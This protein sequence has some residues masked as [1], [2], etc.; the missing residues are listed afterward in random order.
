LGDD[1]LELLV[2]S[3]ELLLDELFEHIQYYLIEKHT[4]WVYEN[5]VLI[6]HTIAKLDNCKLKDY[7]LNFICDD[8]LPFM[9][10]KTFHSTNKEI[11]FELLKR[12]DLLIEEITIWECLIKWGIEQTPGLESNR[13]EWNDENYETLKETL[14]QLIP[15]IRFVEISRADFYDK[16]NPYKAIIPSHI[17]EEVENFYYQDILP[18]LPI[19]TGKIKSNI[20]KPELADIISNWIDKKDAKFTRTSNDPFYKFRLIYRGSRDGIDNKSFKNNC[21]GRVASL[22]LIKVKRSNKIFG[23]Y[24]SIGLNSLGDNCL[25]EYN[26]RFHYSSDNFIFSFENNEDIQNMK[27]GYVTNNSKAI[28]DYANH[29]FNFG[30]GSF[31]MIDQTFQ[32]NS[33][34]NYESISHGRNINDS[35]E[36]IEA[37]IVTKHSI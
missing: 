12:D 26:F 4:Q 33:W 6:L 18:S 15:L 23:G 3:D 7:C 20:I 35:I 27:I 25:L 5:F 34:D 30:W 10:S 32:V 16:V 8:P 11:L 17:Y 24:S 9:S 37:F 2:A 36:E 31:C 21:N 13:T 29:G 1:I 28:M 19:R 14:N 22:I